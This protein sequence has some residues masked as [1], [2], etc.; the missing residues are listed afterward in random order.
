MTVA[1]INFIILAS[2]EILAKMLSQKKKKEDK[3]V[4]VYDILSQNRP[5]IRKN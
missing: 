2:L 4:I 3:V 1:K 5:K